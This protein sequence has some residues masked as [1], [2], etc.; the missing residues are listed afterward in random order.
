MQAVLSPSSLE[1]LYIY[2]A[3]RSSRLDYVE[4]VSDSIRTLVFYKMVADHS[5]LMWLKV[6]PSKGKGGTKFSRIL[7]K[8]TSLKRVALIIPLSK[9]EVY[10]LVHSLEDNHSLEELVLHEVHYTYF[11]K[12]ELQALDPRLKFHRVYPR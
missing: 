4:S 3:G 6:N 8:N 5:G 12:S 9:N 1:I 7:R 10:D 11:P 2:D